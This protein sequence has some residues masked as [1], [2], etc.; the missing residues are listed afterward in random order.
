[1]GWKSLAEWAIAVYQAQGLGAIDSRL[2]AMDVD[3]CYLTEEQ[4][5]RVERWADRLLAE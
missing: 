1:M 4:L 2:E 3:D 5:K